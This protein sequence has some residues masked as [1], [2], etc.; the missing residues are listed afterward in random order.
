MLAAGAAS[1]QGA[2]VGLGVLGYA[3]GAPIVHG[4]HGRG[5]AALGSL[6]LRVGLPIAGAA[7]GAQIKKGCSHSP[8]SNADSF[9]IC[10]DFGYMG[11]GLVTGMLL[12]SALDAGLLS[13]EVND[14]GTD[15]RR[16][17][18][19]IAPAFEPKTGTK[20]VSLSGRF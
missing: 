4:A 8:S 16:L 19:S 11:E 18:F 15:A 2:L 20:G 14:A 7:I 13:W 10:L 17:S 9:D 3:I 5:G 1:D 12:A 6:A